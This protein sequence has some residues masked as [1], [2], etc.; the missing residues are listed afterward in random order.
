[1]GKPEGERMRERR[2]FKWEDDIRIY[3]KEIEW[4]DVDWIDLPRNCGK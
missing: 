1:V 4:E 2:I 3:L